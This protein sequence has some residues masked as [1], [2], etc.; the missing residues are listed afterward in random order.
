M[1]IRGLGDKLAQRL[2]EK[3]IVR[4][5]ADIYALTKEDLA[6]LDR[7][8]EKSAQNL[9]EAIENSKKRSLSALI[10]GLG[11][12]FVGDKV[13]D[14]L[15]EH[16]GSMEAL[17]N[18]SEEDL[19]LVDGIGPVIASSV[20][21]FFRDSANLELLKRFEESG[22]N[23]TG[24][25]NGPR[26]GV[27][28][29]MTVVFTGELRSVARGQAEKRVKELGGK[30]TSSVSAKTSLVVAGENAGSKLVKAK[31]LGIRVIDEAEF[32]TMAMLP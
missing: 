30:A 1:D 3:G 26:K 4:S 14:I 31:T 12:R 13:A 24:P 17:R 16:F 29:G 2:I 10:A 20:E 8:G 23:M 6:K 15:S 21:A 7:M 28:S 19:A 9:V 32:L 5:L 25:T 18:V 11:I 27:F 22:V